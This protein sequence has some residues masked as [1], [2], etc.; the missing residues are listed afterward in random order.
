MTL[1][2]NVDRQAVEQAYLTI[3]AEFGHDTAAEA[4]VGMLCGW[5][6]EHAIRAAHLL[7]QSTRRDNRRKRMSTA[8]SSVVD[9]IRV[10]YHVSSGDAL[11]PA[12]VE[13]LPKH[14]RTTAQYFADGMSGE[15]IAEREDVTPCAIRLRK[16]AIRG[17]LVQ[18]ILDGLIGVDR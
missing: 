6:V 12:I 16:R 1:P 7:N 10:P 4:A 17:A 11:S 3:S 5:P 8:D 18:S 15:A 2:E 9:G 13:R 14:V